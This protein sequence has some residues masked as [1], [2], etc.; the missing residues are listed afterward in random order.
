MSCSLRCYVG[1]TGDCEPIQA[2]GEELGDV[3]GFPDLSWVF[4]KG[5]QVKMSVRIRVALDSLELGIYKGTM[6]M[7]PT[8]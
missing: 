5:G 2:A 7:I 4:S 6:W 8:M 1:N 3:V